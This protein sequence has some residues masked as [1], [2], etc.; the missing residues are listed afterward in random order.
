MHDRKVKTGIGKLLTKMIVVIT[1]MFS[2]SIPLATSASPASVVSYPTP[3]YFAT[4]SAY[5][6]LVD[7]TTVKVV[8]HFDY[9][10]AQLSYSGTATFKVT[11][12]QAITSYDISPHSYGIEA[13]VS[14][15]EL[16]FSLSQAGSRYLVIK[17][18]N[19]ENLVIMTDP[20]ETGA[21]VP[22]GGSVKSIM[23]YSGVDNT[24]S[25]LMTSK[26]QQAINDANA[27]SGGGTVYF[28]AGIY[29]I[30]QFELKSNVTLYLAAGAVLRGSTTLSDYDFTDT[31]FKQSNIRIVGASNVAIKGRGMIDSN[32]TLL[33]TND[34]GPNRENIIRSYKNSAGTKPNN[35]T[36]EG[37]TL[38]D[39]TTW[40]FNIEEST[41]VKITNVKILNNVHW[42]HGDGFDLVNTSHAVVDQCFAYTGDDVFDAKSSTEEPMT[43]VVYKNSVAY[44]ESAGTKAGVAGQG[45]LTDLWFINIDVILAYRGISLS[46]DEGNGVWDDIH[47]IDI[48][49]EKIFNNGPNGQFRTAP[50]LIWTAKYGTQVGPI[51]NVELTRITF[52][53]INN[54]HSII[55]GYDSSSKVS[56]VNI[57]NLKINGNMIADPSQGLIDIGANT[58][59]ITFNTATTNYMI[60]NVNSGKIVEVFGG[61]TTDGTKVVQWDYHAGKNQRWELVDA[62][63]GYYKIKNVKSGKVLDVTGGSTA[64][65]AL[66]VQWT[67][68]GGDNQQWK[69]VDVGGGYVKLI[70]RNS[71]KALDSTGSTADGVQLT[72]WEDNGGDNQKWQLFSQ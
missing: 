64:N 69:I 22:N 19:L 49:T 13:T 29:K 27:R 12:S 10:F 23:D 1:L 56:N 55:Q 17:V 67:E 33:T 68:N 20:L 60:T 26:I 58:S 48:R 31:N 8:K 37:I 72:Q 5:S 36:F 71:G 61:G 50:L 6:L 3:S 16:T 35:L 41:N 52:E 25:N 47:F 24:G 46:H 34:F 32:G 70:N 11:A 7:S 53:N 39:G 45:S 57:T 15:K 2:F 59:N 42:V 9:S 18:N 65:G 51:S 62:G 66:V 40:N 38:R 4:S 43:D 30:S 14:G 21:P 63:G 44:T 28:P 54:Y